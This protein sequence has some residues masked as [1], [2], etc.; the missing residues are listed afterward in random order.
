MLRGYR[1]IRDVNR[2]PPRYWNEMMDLIR[3]FDRI[4]HII[5]ALEHE[6][7]STQHYAERVA[8]DRDKSYDDREREIH[9]ILNKM[10]S[11]KLIQIE[12]LQD[13]GNIAR[14]IETISA[15]IYRLH[16]N[17]RPRSLLVKSA[18]QYLFTRGGRS[19]V[20]RRNIMVGIIPIRLPE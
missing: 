9:E 3:E 12:F 8:N 14:Q 15:R 17:N 6:V 20:P 5:F 18:L 13:L 19:W 1:S 16:M 7:D 4:Q 2:N 10:D 11:I